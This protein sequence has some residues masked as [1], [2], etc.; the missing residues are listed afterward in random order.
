[1]KTVMTIARAA[2]P[3]VEST[4]CNPTFAKIATR[5]AKKA[6]RVANKSHSIPN[7]F[8]SLFML[9]LGSQ[10]FPSFIGFRLQ[11]VFYKFKL[12]LIDVAV[13]GMEN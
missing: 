4:P 9:T 6:E 5:A 1:M 12:S 7:V 8:H 13:F 11:Q 10:Y 2:V 3:T